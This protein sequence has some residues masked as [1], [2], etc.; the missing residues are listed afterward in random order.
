MK[1]IHLTD[2]HLVPPGQMLF[3][4]DPHRRL[5]AAVAD[6]NRRHAD[7]ALCVI[8]GDLA[9]RGEVAA[10]EVLKDCLAA[11]CVPARLVLGNHDDRDAFHRVFPEAPVDAGGFS[12]SALD[13][14]AGR[15]LFLDTLQPGSH[16][17]AYCAGRRGWLARELDRARTP[18]YVFMHHPPFPL[19]YRPMDEIGIKDAETALQPMLAAYQDKIRHIFFGH[20][21]RPVSGSWRGIPFST[22]RG[23]N[24]QVWLDFSV[25]RGI[26]CS[27]EPPAYGIVF[28]DPEGTIVH[29]HDYLDASPKFLYGDDG[30]LV[31]GYAALTA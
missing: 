21:H 18:V 4:L 31:A 24:H 8:T 6:I 29:S 12:Q 19:R 16:A 10:Y 1:L 23:T 5:A 22:L 25:E 11:L 7:A 28:L 20:V 30:R 26:P 14:A 9:H 13:T 2:T 17:G 27:H 15:F 3:E